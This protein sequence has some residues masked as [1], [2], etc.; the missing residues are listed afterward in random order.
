MVRQ[1]VGSP[2]QLLHLSHADDLTLA[3]SSETMLTSYSSGH[4]DYVIEIID[5]NLGKSQGAAGCDID[6]D[7]RS[8]IKHSGYRGL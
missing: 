1:N 7:F 2:G 6:N 8:N 5:L 3:S 4:L